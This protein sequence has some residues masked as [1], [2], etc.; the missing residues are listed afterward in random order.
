M[1]ALVEARTVRS[2]SRRTGVSSPTILSL[3][4]RFVVDL[5]SRLRNRVQISTDGPALHVEVVERAFGADAD[6]TQIVRTYEAE[7]IGPG[8]YSPPKMTSANKVAIVAAPDMRRASTSRVERQNRA[9][10]MGIRRMT[11]LT[12]A[13]SKKLENHRADVSLH[14]AHY[15]FV[16]RHQL[17]RVTPAEREMWSM[18][19]LA[20]LV[21]DGEAA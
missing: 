7:S 16:H 6:Y 15:N 18:G 3:L 1:N 19:Q 9:L 20:A 13:F 11:R 4:V 2:T 12:D 14:F 21:L 8:R 5:R 17:L 10:R